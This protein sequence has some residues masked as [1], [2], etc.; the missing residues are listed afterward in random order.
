MYFRGQLR[1]LDGYNLSRE[2]VGETFRWRKGAIHPG[3]ASKTE[4]RQ[5]R[6]GADSKES[7]I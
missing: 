1:D 6:R 4:A 3:A 7:R 2:T 5:C